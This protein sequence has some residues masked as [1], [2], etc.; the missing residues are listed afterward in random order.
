MTD[1]LSSRQIKQHNN[2]ALTRSEITDRIS[3]AGRL[4]PLVELARGAK[5]SRSHGRVDG[6]VSHLIHLLRDDSGDICL[7]EMVCS[8]AGYRCQG[9][10]LGAVAQGFAWQLR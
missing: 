10:D 1:L 2:K 4:E 9:E 6:C 8:V 5:L 7:Q 3:V